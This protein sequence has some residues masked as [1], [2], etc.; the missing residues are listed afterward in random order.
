MNGDSAMLKSV[1]NPQIKSRGFVINAEEIEARK[2]AAIKT[3]EEKKP[4]GPQYL[5][6]E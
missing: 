4:K 6:A 3:A 1:P 5:Q 2:T